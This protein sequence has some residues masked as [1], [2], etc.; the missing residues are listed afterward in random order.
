MD[1][2]SLGA[3][4]IKILDYIAAILIV[5]GLNLVPKTANGWL[6]YL[7]G[8]V[9]YAIVVASNHLWGLFFM[10]IILMVT[11]IKNYLIEKEMKG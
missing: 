11:A 9:F 8:G 10:N 1:T 5:V 3:Y 7:I 2:I 6:V 4:M